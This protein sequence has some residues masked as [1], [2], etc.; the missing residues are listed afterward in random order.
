MKAIR[1]KIDFDHGKWSKEQPGP[2][3][4]DSVADTVED[5]D[6]DAVEGR[7]ADANEPAAL[8]SSVP[9]QT[10]DPA[11]EETDGR[12]REDGAPVSPLEGLRRAH[13]IA[14]L[15]AVGSFKIALTMA[16]IGTF[17]MSWATRAAFG[18][19][20]FGSVRSS[21]SDRPAGPDKDS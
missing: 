15:Y 21:A 2:V 18:G 4:E 9:R 10:E 5:R 16:A 11:C 12:A 20:A 7:V 6:A 17:S 3:V 19:A 14:H 13:E 1:V 8:A